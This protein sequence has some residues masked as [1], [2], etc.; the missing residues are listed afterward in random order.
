MRCQ[1]PAFSRFSSCAQY[2][3][4]RRNR[5]EVGTFVKQ[6]C[7]DLSHAKVGEAFAMGGVENGLTFEIGQSSMRCSFPFGQ[8]NAGHSLSPRHAGPRCSERSTSATLAEFYCEPF[9]DFFDDRSSALS[10][11][12]I[13]K[14]AC[15]FPRASIFLSDFPGVVAV[16][17]SRR[18]TPLSQRLQGLPGDLASLVQFRGV[19]YASC[20]QGSCIRL[21]AASSQRARS[22]TTR[23]GTPQG[24]GL[25]RRP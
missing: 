22:A 8:L 17:H 15:A 18:V 3:I 9:H 10:P 4:D 23:L 21:L 25:Y 13:C 19:A 7:V 14:S 2:P 6:G 12:I 24:F 5:P 11:A 20:I 16:D 1:A